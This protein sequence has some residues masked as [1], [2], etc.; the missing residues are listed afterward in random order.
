VKLTPTEEAMIEAVA[1]ADNLDTIEDFD[2][3]LAAA[4]NDMPVDPREA[5][6]SEELG[7]VVGEVTDADGTTKVAS[8]MRRVKDTDDWENYITLYS[9][10][11]GMPSKV[12]R[13]MRVKKLRQVWPEVNSIPETLWGKPVFTTKPLRKYVV[14]VSMCRLN[15]D[16]PDRDAVVAAGLGHLSCR[17]SN[18][19]TEFAARQHLQHKHH[20]EFAALEA[21]RVTTE[22][23]AIKDKAEENNA[24]LR[25][26]LQELAAQRRTESSTS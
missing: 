10:L 14:G 15:P 21:A 6:R 18:M 7:E 4:V 20:D 17:K 2:A 25:G 3:A 19:P 13:G 11:D 12:L 9:T 26:L 23:T 16:H 8:S 24:L 1:A 22:E 5:L